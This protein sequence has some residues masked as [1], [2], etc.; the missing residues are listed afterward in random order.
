MG[1]D[2]IIIDGGNL[3]SYVG[4]NWER[5]EFISRGGALQA[6][7]KSSEIMFAKNLTIQQAFLIYQVHDYYNV[8]FA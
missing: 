3:I 1:N 7:C 6:M 2:T 8:S 5:N 4:M